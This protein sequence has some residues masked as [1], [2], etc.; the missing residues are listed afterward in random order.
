MM[1]RLKKLKMELLCDLTPGGVLFRPL[2]CVHFS[3]TSAL[4]GKQAARLWT[5]QFRSCHSS[6][7]DNCLLLCG[8]LIQTEALLPREK[9]VI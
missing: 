9:G 7:H 5:L 1:E 3:S 2:S 6:P 8:Y 4:K